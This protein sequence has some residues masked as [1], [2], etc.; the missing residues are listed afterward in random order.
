M[1]K[2]LLIIALIGAGYQ[3]WS[4]GGRWFN[5][6][7]PP[8]NG[9][10]MYSLST[11]GNCVVTSRALH[12]AGVVFTELY[13][14]EDRVAEDELHRKMRNAGLDTSFYYTPVL[15]VKGDILSNNPK[16]KII[17]DKIKEKDG[18]V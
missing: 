5:P 9:I 7:N 8:H 16:L 4:N 15:D 12:Q 2:R 10:I 3:F 17:I 6:G 13:I 18:A 14:D 1:G 11:C